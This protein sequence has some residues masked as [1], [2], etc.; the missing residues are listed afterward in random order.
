M[1]DQTRRRGRRA[2]AWLLWVLLAA[3][4]PLGCS[5]SDE[6]VAVS[7][8]ENESPEVAKVRKA[9]ENADASLR[10]PVE[11]ALKV[12]QSGASADALSALTRLAGN[13]KLSA[14]QKQAL[15]ELVQKLK[16]ASTAR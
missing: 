7:G 9:F 16:G 11:D 2:A 5:K 10:L 8:G 4:A 12:V 14:E 13:P 3:S 15:E 1:D 6:R